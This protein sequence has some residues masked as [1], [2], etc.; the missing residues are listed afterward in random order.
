MSLFNNEEFKTG[1]EAKRKE[2][3]GNIIYDHIERIVGIEKAPKLCGM[4]IDLPHAELL[5]TLQSLECL[6]TKVNVG[7]D[8]LIKVAQGKEKKE[9]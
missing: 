6:T 3:I 5:E 1:N 8:L 7:V 2:L 9:E 4:V